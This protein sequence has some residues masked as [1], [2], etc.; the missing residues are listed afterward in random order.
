MRVL[1]VLHQFLPEFN[2]GTERFAYNVAR[3]AQRAG[4][5]V[6]VLTCAVDEHKWEKSAHPLLLQA[7]ADGIPVTALPRRLVGRRADFD[8]TLPPAPGREAF[9]EFFFNR[10]FDVCHVVHTMRMYGALEWLMRKQLPYVVSLTDFYLMCYRVNLVKA[11]GGLCAGPRQGRACASSCAVPEFSD[12]E[13][14]ERYAVAKTVLANA[15]AVIA[16]SEFVA[17]AFRREF[18]GLSIKT[19]AHGVDLP[20]WQAAGCTAVP[21]RRKS[22]VTLGYLGTLAEEK[23]VRTLVDGFAQLAAAHMRLR[24]VGNPGGSKELQDYLHHMA[25]SDPRISV[26][27]GV[28]FAEAPDVLASFDVVCIPSL[29][30]ETFSLVLHEAFAAGLPVIVSDIG[31]LGAVV[32]ERQCGALVRPGS[33]EAWTRVLGD[34]AQSPALVAQWRSRIPL[35]VRIEEEAFFYETCYR[36]ALASPGTLT[37][38]S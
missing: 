24:L 30:P 13:L 26:E 28:S 23:G 34:V 29:V 33:K 18:T 10:E 11:V 32:R 16:C 22:E 19:Q 21:G 35:A 1:I 8:L 7:C 27:A 14:A 2:S 38:V 17:D 4:H 36:A 12:G 31:N 20:L 5:F 25:E 9:A 6:E 3:S 37:C 15:S